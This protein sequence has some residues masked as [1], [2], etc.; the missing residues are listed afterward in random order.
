[1]LSN[2]LLK[3]LLN[4][5]AHYNSELSARDTLNFPQ[6]AEPLTK[7]N[8]QPIVTI[9]LTFGLT[10]ATRIPYVAGRLD[11]TGTSTSALTVVPGGSF[12]AK[13]GA[14]EPLSS[15]NSNRSTEYSVIGVVSVPV[16]VKV[17]VC[18]GTTGSGEIVT[19]SSGGGVLD[20]GHG[21]NSVVLYK[22]DVE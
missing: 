10:I 4:G 13:G 21:P 20:T 15:P 9:G 6:E 17:V 18:P 3:R 19:E 16:I 7:V 1:S 12:A 8:A 14:T 5:D 11:G 2:N 22:V